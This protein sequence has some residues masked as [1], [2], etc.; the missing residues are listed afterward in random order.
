MKK[1][2]LLS[3]LFLAGWAAPARA[4]TLADIRT[5]IRRNVRQTASDGGR[6]TDAMINDWINEG[7]REIVNL[8][9]CVE[10]STSYVLSAGTTYYSLPTNFLGA[11]LVTFTDRHGL[12]IEMD[13]SSFHKIYQ[14]ES[15]FEAS[16]T[17]PPDHYFIRHPGTAGTTLQIAYIPVPTTTS[18]GT[19]KMWYAYFPADLSADSSV[20]FDGFNHLKPYHYALVAHVTAKIKAIEGKYDEAGFYLKELERYVTTMEARFGASPNYSPSVQGAP[21]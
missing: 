12:T 5:Q 1:L 6:Y 2:L 16:S 15:D 11:K 4:L 14:Q 13:E 9:W 19:V 3:L 7:Q 17:G 18:T 10:M 21:K 20:P 8:T